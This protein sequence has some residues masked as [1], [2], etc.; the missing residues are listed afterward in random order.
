[1]LARTAGGDE[2]VDHDLMA[3]LTDK[4]K[5][6]DRLFKEEKGMVEIANALTKRIVERHEGTK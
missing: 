3:V 2:T 5:D 1:M 6:R 4:G